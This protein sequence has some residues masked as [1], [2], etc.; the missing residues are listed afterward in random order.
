MTQAVERFRLIAACIARDAWP[1]S[2]GDL[3]ERLE[4]ARDRWPGL[5]A[6]A[7]RF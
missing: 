7:H 5:L 2:P 3:G 1:G 4:R 6:L